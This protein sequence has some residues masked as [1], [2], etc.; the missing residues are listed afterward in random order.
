MSG[1]KAC[2]G[3]ERDQTVERRAESRARATEIG[4]KL[5][6]PLEVQTVHAYRRVRLS[7]SHHTFHTASY[8]KN[9]DSLASFRGRYSLTT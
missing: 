7:Q 9:V 4:D 8:G 2:S 1:K 3:L 5:G 6:R